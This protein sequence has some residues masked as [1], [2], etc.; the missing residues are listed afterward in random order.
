MEIDILIQA[1][2][3]G[4]VMGSL[5]SLM[6]LGVTLI[7]GMMHIP[8]FAHGELYMLGSVAFYYVFE[9]FGI[10][11]PIAFLMA[12]AALF[13]LGVILERFVI[14]P[15]KGDTKQQLIATVGISMVAMSTAF[16]TFGLRPKAVS[17]IF[18]GISKIGEIT[19]PNERLS[20]V[21]ASFVLIL[22]LYLFMQK[23]KLGRACRAVSMNADAAQLQGVNVKNM[24]ALVWGLAAA[25]AAAGGCLIAPIF[26]VS[27][28]MGVRPV[29]IAFV[30]VIIGGLGSVPG[31]LVCALLI[32]IVEALVATF[33][34]MEFA[35]GAV[36][37]T[38]ILVILV[39][40]QG[41]FK[42]YV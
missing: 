15:I 28:A 14:R 11:W 29:A 1:L 27:P 18:P 17:T 30:T 25:L 13:L 8:N 37:L 10:P 33:I 2:V 38:A 4:L 22:L 6:A 32:G 20:A 31:A 9:V 21:V 42:G 34:G 16:V 41:L 36:F 3:N 24:H 12:F 7:F 39:R 40:P 5:Y 23:T 26:S 35:W 19:V